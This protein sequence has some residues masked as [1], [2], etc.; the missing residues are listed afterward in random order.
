[1]ST[2]NK[3]E[4]EFYHDILEGLSIYFD[5]TL[6]VDILNTI[7]KQP[8]TDFGNAFNRN[9]L[10]S[11]KWLIDRLIDVTDGNFHD[12]V[13]LG[14]WYGVLS[15]LLLNDTRF[16]MQSIT[17]IDIN[18]DCAVVAD[19]LNQRFGEDGT[20]R[21]LT[22]DMFKLDYNA[23]LPPP[24]DNSADNLLINTSCE[25]IVD[26]SEWYRQVPVGTTVILQSNNFFDCGEHV[27]CV[28]NVSELQQLAP[29]SKTLFAGDLP[30]KK[31][32]RF[33]LIGVK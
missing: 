11:K 19:C 4:K 28:N 18:P 12:I 10:G 8:R 15:A 6:I 17:S 31:Y 14:G 30:L 32:T 27:N 9:Q 20:F 23:L 22:G 25:H 3:Q 33:M 16:S 21:A 26:F 29:V 5:N 7:N 13:V 1:M 24:S 2:S